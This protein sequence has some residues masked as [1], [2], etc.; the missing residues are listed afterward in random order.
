MGNAT[1]DPG[2]VGKRYALLFAGTGDRWTLND[3]EY[4]YR[5][6]VQHYAF[7]PGDVTVLYFD[8]HIGTNTSEPTTFWPN[9]TPPD[10]YQIVINKP[11]TVGNFTA[12]W[13][14][15]AAKLTQNDMVFVHVNGHGGV[16]AATLEA[17]VLAFDGIAYT[18]GQL[19]ADL[20]LLPAH[21][22]LLIMMQQC[23]CSGF[24]NPVIHAKNQGK[25]RAGRVSL[26]CASAGISYPDPNNFFDSFTRG[27]VAAYVGKDP[28][29]KPLIP[30]VVYDN[31]G[32][33]E[34]F[35]AYRYARKVK[36][37]DDEPR[38]RNRPAGAKNIRL[39]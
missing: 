32:F 33:V 25:I 28:F 37:P 34:A 23:Y 22:S 29:G 7:K 5:T 3:L 12:A 35:E 30:P 17:F 39:A 31:S 1:F 18:A 36:D 16:D 15:L 8:G 24:I 9:E 10:R 38:Q 27:W 14:A 20:A 2:R 11:G 26:A 13:V 21:A 4:C 6:L 19:C